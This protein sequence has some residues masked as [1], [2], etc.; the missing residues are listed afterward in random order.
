MRILFTTLRNTSHFLPLIPFVK[1]CQARGHEVAV[2]APP[3]LAERV[4]TTGAA[5]FP[6]GHPGDEG[7]RPI[8]Q[9]LH[10]AAPAELQRI[11]IR[12]IFA[13]AC[14]AA[15]YPVLLETMQQWK[16]SLVVRESQEYAAVLATEKLGIPR[17]RVSITLRSAELQL[18]PDAAPTVDDHAQRL[19]LREDPTGQRILREPAVTQFPASLDPIE[20]GQTPAGRFRAARGAGAAGA[21][22]AWWGNQTGP[23]VY[24]T[25]GTVAG[26][27]EPLRAAYRTAL[28]A[29]STLPLRV[30]LTIGAELAPETLGEVPANVHVERFVPQDD[31]LPHAAAVICHG[32]SGTVIGTLAAGVPMVVMPLFA[33][34]PNNA[35]RVTAIGAGIGLPTRTT[36]SDAIRSALSRVLEE[37]SF[38]SSAQRVA[39]E[40]AALPPVSEAALE[41]ERV[42]NA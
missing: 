9:R 32:G 1:A 8:W 25:L 38:R 20:S 5:F 10:G 29:V 18:L 22:P 26:G 37:G 40:I 31:V 34:Q 42:A 16:P 11:V 21:L 33:D 15:A 7:L 30:L 14:A 24:L 27:M 35:E 3:D 36:S 19:G 41:L 4:A 2:A 17:V 12:E 39:S 23:L 28:D 6:F 13:G